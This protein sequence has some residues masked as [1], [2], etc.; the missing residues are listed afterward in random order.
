MSLKIQPRALP[1]GWLGVL[2]LAA[3]IH[4]WSGISN[5]R[6]VN[7]LY[8]ITQTNGNALNG[9][10]LR[11]INV[12]GTGATIITEANQ[13]TNASALAIDIYANSVTKC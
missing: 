6:A 2:L 3:F 9:D 4:W 5:V 12:D 13:I 10:G 8:Y 1:V 7:V 11:K